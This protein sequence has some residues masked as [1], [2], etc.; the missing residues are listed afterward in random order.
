MQRLW[1]IRG[2]M[3]LVLHLHRRM[4]LRFTRWAGIRK[5]TGAGEIYLCKFV[6]EGEKYAT[7]PG[8]GTCTRTWP[9]YGTS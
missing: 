9:N 7:R 3:A 2:T 6:N 8:S 4:R 5:N 1:L